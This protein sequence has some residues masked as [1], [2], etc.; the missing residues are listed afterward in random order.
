MAEGLKILENVQGFNIENLK[1]DEPFVSAVMNASQAA[2]REH[3]RQ[4]L[5]SLRDAVLN[6]ARGPDLSED[7]EVIFLFLMNQF[8]PWHLRILRFFE[9]PLEL[10]KQK[11]VTPENY[12]V[13]SRTQLR[14]DYYPEMHGKQQF[15][16]VV[17]ADLRSNGMLGAGLRG[18]MTRL[19]V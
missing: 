8:T 14:E 10:A 4:K 19:R 2:M 18:M 3:P 5:D 13:G 6:V 1:D 17:V 12:Y 15:Y 16:G 11:G 9:R 7:E